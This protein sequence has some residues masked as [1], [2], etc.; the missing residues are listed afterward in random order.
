MWAVRQKADDSL[1]GHCG[2]VVNEPP[3]V[4]L[5]YALARNAW[6]RGLAT[7]A[8]ERVT[9]FAVE[10]RALSELV[11]LVFPDNLASVHVLE[12]LGFQ[13]AGTTL[14]FDSDLLRFVRREQPPTEGH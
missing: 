6:G 13:P 7:E 3:D 8:A 12:K 11:A 14:R 10:E 9:R 2:L 1:V 4:E 5:I